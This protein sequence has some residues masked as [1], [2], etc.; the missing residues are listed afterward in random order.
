MTFSFPSAA[1]GKELSSPFRHMC[2]YT[3][4]KPYFIGCKLTNRCLPVHGFSV[5][6][7]FTIQGHS[8]FLTLLEILHFGKEF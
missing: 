3:N 4:T 1:Q 8:E 6:R 7:I 2:I 5:L